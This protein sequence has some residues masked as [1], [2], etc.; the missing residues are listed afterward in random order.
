MRATIHLAT[1][2]DCLVLRSVLQPVLERMFFSGSPFGRTL[3]GIDLDALLAA[4]R[5]LVEERPRT[6][7]ELRLALG[8]RWP[9]RDPS[10]LAYA[11]SYLLPVVQVPPRG[12]WRGTG[13]STW[14][15]IE[16]WLGRPLRAR[17]PP[18]EIIL[19][20]LAAFGP[21]TTADMRTWSGLP[22]LREVVERLRPR[23]RTF[24]DDHGR[25][26]FDV[27][28]APLP[29]PDVPAPTRFLPEYDNALLSHADRSR[30]VG[31]DERRAF[32]DA[33]PNVGAVLVNG[34]GRAIWRIARDGDAATLHVRPLGR[35]SKKDAAS[36][37]KEGTALLAFVA[38]DAERRDVLLELGD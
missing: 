34:F 5:A 31:G 23:L 3:D 28:G 4:G 7:S 10:S 32:P 8:E 37:T 29:D 11:I 18:D 19:R 25:E 33:G 22:G 1:A 17:Q 14:T 9:D 27:P 30:V 13:Q 2:P 21:A 16:S 15:T 38:A 12:L 36:V 35:L 24:R 6:R 26:L 20:Y